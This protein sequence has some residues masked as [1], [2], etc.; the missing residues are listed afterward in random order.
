MAVTVIALSGASSAPPPSETPLATVLFPGSDNSVGIC[1]RDDRSRLA[2]ATPRTSSIT[3]RYNRTGR[4][5]LE[6]V[7]LAF[8]VHIEQV[9]GFTQ[10]RGVKSFIKPLIN[11]DEEIVGHHMPAV[12][13][14]Q[15]S[16]A[17]GG[18]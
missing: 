15:A 12:I 13:S 9:A 8:C 14:V 2:F 6:C 11:R 1:S 17:E 16:Q 7:Y 3:E 4:P 18:A 10:I 5:P